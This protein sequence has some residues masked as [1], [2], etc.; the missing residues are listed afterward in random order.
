VAPPADLAPA[1]FIVGVPR[2][3]T[4]LLR[5]QLDAH[6]ELALPAE[7][8]FGEVARRFEGSA[9]TREEL[10]EALTSMPTWP[11]LSMSREALAELL[12]EVEDGD[13]SAGLR[14]FFR[15]Y[16]AARG[17][18]RYGDKTPGHVGDMDVLSRVL[19][20]ARFIHLIRD[21]RD[22]AASLRGLPF[23]PGD[24]GIAAIAAAW[25]DTIWRARRVAAHL[26]HYTEVRYEDLVSEPER[27]LRELCDFL[28]LEFA[29]EMLRAHERA[30][31]RLA[32]MRS[33]TVGPDGVIHLQDGTEVVA[34]TFRPPQTDRVGRW[35]HSLSEYEVTRFERFA[36]GAL[37]QSGYPAYR[38]VP[39]HAVPLGQVAGRNPSMKVVLGRQS[40][41]TLGGSETYALTVAR[42]LERLGHDVTLV[43]E[44][45]GIAAAVAGRRGI[46]IARLDEAPSGCDAVIAH[47]LPMAVALAARYPDAR[48]VFVIHSDGWDLQ[49]PPLVPG[50][51]DAVVACSDRFAARARALPLEV[52]IIRLREPVDTDAYLFTTALPERP[53]QALIVSNYLQGE[54]RRMLVDAWENAG[55]ECVQA[56]APTEVVIDLAPAL[57]SADIVVAKGRAALE[58]M[59]AGR[60][61][62]LYDQYGGDGWVT[63]DN[64]PALEADHFGGQ[65]TPRPRTG[66]DLVADLADYSP[67]MGVVNHELVRSHHGARSHAIEI[68]A[69]LRG[70]YVREADQV[71]V[72]AEIARLARA[73]GRAD[74]L[75]GELWWRMTTAEARVADAERRAGEAERQLG[76]ARYLLD[77]KRARAGLAL[78]RAAD[79]LRSRA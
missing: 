35:R 7:T 55:I 41:A 43:A 18:A 73:S 77:T 45:L 76:D 70:A 60:A 71:E 78:G 61:V 47:D 24:G 65:A 4:T 30:R 6:P 5:L 54:R 8:G 39:D 25:R 57:A 21:G 13:L 44:E 42:E 40:L 37:E 20:E 1:P 67:E 14:A 27:V 34:R 58:G 2:S 72:T 48:R 79:R 62:Y 15:G 66:A 32:E 9:V 16:A 22:V 53:G 64:Y 29:P 28:E 23:A 19:P 49:L 33:A 59:C 11:D 17:K 31:E 46:R 68:V 10:L 3:G 50:L 63:P 26:P 75:S 69:V 51:V 52:P 12:A 36:G 74:L 56:G 38:S